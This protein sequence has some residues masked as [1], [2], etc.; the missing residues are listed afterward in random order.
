[1]RVIQ[2]N[3][4]FRIIEYVA[5]NGHTVQ[6]V[7]PKVPLPPLARHYGTCAK[8]MSFDERHSDVDIDVRSPAGSAS[9]VEEAVAKH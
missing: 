7:K 9:L 8:D 3:P 1:M 2:D 4:V 5:P 6:A